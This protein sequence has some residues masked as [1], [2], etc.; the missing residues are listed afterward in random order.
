MKIMCKDRE[1]TALEAIQEGS[2]I[3]GV[4][5]PCLLGLLPT[6]D[7]IDSFVPDYIWHCTVPPV[8]GGEETLEG[9]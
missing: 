9:D 2:L 7:I 1:T 5:G 8:S 3:N 4:K 6:F